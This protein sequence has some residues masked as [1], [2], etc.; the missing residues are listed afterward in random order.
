MHLSGTKQM[1]ILALYLCPHGPKPAIV[2]CLCLLGSCLCLP[3]TCLQ[4]HVLL[5]NRTGYAL[6]LLQ[7]DM[8]TASGPAAAAMI[9]GNLTGGLFEGGPMGQSAA[10]RKFFADSTYHK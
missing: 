1:N 9:S 4:H 5:A 8:P 2:S 10:K 7:P 6:E 3:L